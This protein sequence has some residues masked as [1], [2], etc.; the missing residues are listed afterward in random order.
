MRTS[1]YLKPVAGALLLFI[2][3]A[4]LAAIAQEHRP[5]VGMG[6]LSVWAVVYGFMG[7]FVFATA[8]ILGVQE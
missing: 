5:F 7:L 8:L 2:L 3:S 6:F 4:V 1:P